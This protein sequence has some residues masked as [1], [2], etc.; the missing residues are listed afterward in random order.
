MCTFIHSL[1]ALLSFTRLLISLTTTDNRSSPT[2]CISPIHNSVP[3]NSWLIPDSCLLLFFFPLLFHLFPSQFRCHF[4]PLLTESWY[5]S[6]C[7]RWLS[8]DIT[9]III[10]TGFSDAY[11]LVGRPTQLIE[12][13]A[14]SSIDRLVAPTVLYHRSPG[15]SNPLNHGGTGS[16]DCL[17][18]VLP[19]HT[20]HH[21]LVSWIKN[22]KVIQFYLLEI[23]GNVRQCNS[24]FKTFKFAN[25]WLIINLAGCLRP[26]IISAAYVALGLLCPLLPSTKNTMNNVP[27]EFVF[28]GWDKGTRFQRR[29]SCLQSELSTINQSIE[30]S[31][32]YPFVPFSACSSCLPYA[33]A[34]DRYGSFIDFI[35]YCRKLFV[36]L[37]FVHFRFKTYLICAIYFNNLM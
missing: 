4:R 35:E 19:A 37:C 17:L 26:S 2:D 28:E 24:S 30:C 6:P 10:S 11:P 15:Y 22:L 14:I 27:G 20:P 18:Q 9:P 21:G 5:I 23:I 31:L 7:F 3:L 1:S 33:R 32:Q 36:N 16:E 25:Y 8:I 29:G 13:P 12:R 34:L